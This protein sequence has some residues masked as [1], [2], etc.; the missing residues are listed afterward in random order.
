MGLFVCS[1]FFASFF[2]RTFSLLNDNGANVS[3]NF[4]DLYARLF[5]DKRVTANGLNNGLFINCKR[6]INCVFRIYTFFRR[7]SRFNFISRFLANYVSRRTPFQRL[8]SRDMV[9]KILYFNDYKGVREGSV[10]NDV[11]FFQ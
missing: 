7:L 9:S 3:V 5:E 10:T 8:T 6:S 4:N 2:R 11:R 1:R